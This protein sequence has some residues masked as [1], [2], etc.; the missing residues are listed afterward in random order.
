[1]S[2]LKEKLQN[3]VRNQ[4]SNQKD[5]ESLKDTLN[6]VLFAKAQ[7][8]KKNVLIP[9]STLILCGYNRETVNESIM[10]LREEGLKAYKY[11]KSEGT[12]NR[13]ECLYISWGD[14]E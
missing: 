9:I 12:R 7:E 8:G 1:M 10:W 11:T 4:K 3:L 14:T 2:N 5:L 6:D 13:L